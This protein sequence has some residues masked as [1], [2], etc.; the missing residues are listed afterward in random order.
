[1][2]P[3]GKECAVGAA[4]GPA[5]YA[6]GKLSGFRL[7]PLRGKGIIIELWAIAAAT[8]ALRRVMRSAMLTSAAWGWLG[9]DP[10]EGGCHNRG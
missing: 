1:M 9:R 7:S 8:H 10:R 2:N 5:S 4:K 6:C 3:R